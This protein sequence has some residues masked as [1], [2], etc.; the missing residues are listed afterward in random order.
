MDMLSKWILTII[1]ILIANS[2]V[3]GQDKPGNV[4]VVSNPPGAVVNLKG[5][6]TLT[7]I[8]PIN[9]SRNLDGM[10]QLSVRK[11]GYEPYQATLFL[12]IGIPQSYTIN[13][14]SKTRFKAI[15][16]SF[17]IPGWGQAYSGQKLKGYLFFGLAAGAVINYFAAD[18]DFKDK[19]DSFNDMEK[20][21][22]DLTKTEEK[23]LMF[24]ELTAAKKDAYDAESKRRVATGLMIAAWTVNIIDLLFH[25]PAHDRRLKVNSISIE[26]DLEQGGGQLVLTHRF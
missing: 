11:D 17:L 8:T 19:N 9:F 20:E 25:F 7:G 22:N 18:S 4:S 15:A 12:Q 16:R 23:E 2:F 21:Y 24:P 26:P 6:I 14:K 5:D 3:F 13:L 1:I 10:Y